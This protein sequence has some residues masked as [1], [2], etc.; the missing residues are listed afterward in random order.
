MLKYTG[1]SIVMQEVPDEVSLAVVIAGCQHKCPDCHSKY[2]WE[3]KGQPLSEH[4]PIM[5]QEYKKYI[6]CFCLMGGDQDQKELT[7]ICKK[8]HKEGLKTCLY[9]GYDEFSQI[10][11]SL[12]N[13]LD[14]IKLG[15]F[16]KEKGP[17]NR[18][19]TNQRMYQKEYSPFSDTDEWVDITCKFW[20]RKD[21]E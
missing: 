12:L 11:Q 20:P 21:L 6:T 2:T 8:V 17:L 14:Y 13:E 16:D 19:T 5:L 1:G 7:D 9:T 3:D 4:L 18:K 15:R 10:S